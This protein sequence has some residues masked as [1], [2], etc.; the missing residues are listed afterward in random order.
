MAAQLNL[1]RNTKVFISTVDLASGGA[2]TSVVPANTWQVEILAGY[3]VSQA[4]ATQ[5]IT[6]LESGTSPDRSQQRFNTALNPVDWNFQAYLKPTGM[7]KTSGSTGKHASGNSMPVAD[8]FMWQAMMSNVSWASGS[9]LRSNWQDDGKFALAE[10]AGASNSYPHSANFSTASEYHLYFQMD[11]VVYQVANATV[12]Q[13]SIDAAIDGIATTTW[14]GFGTN[15]IEL[16]NDA[17]NNAISVFG[18]VLNSGSSATANSNAY[19]LTAQAAYHPWNSYN[20]AGSISSASFIKN[21]LSTITIQHA[22]SASGAGV[23]F[24]FPVTAL[25]FDYNNNI[26]YLTP[27]ELASLNSPIGQFAGARAI[28]G[29][30]SAYLRS[31]SSDTAQF[32]K[33]VV[34]DTR[35]T[36]AATSNANLRIGGSTAPYFAINMPAVA[37]ELPTHA[38]EDIIGISVNFLAQETAKGTGDEMTLIVAKS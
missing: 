1:Q 5:D 14:T 13:G 31:G 21:R 7:N 22:P 25:S 3:A 35:T 29:S 2:V 16:R 36:S 38:V 23:T 4:A 27:E 33:Q 32:L 26:T 12:N 28:T 37:F 9:A 19:A 10:R 11:N 24:T 8:W 17:R 34:E 15:L 18:G 20:V 30:L 6:S